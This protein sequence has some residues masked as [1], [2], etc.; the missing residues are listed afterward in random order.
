[1]NGKSDSVKSQALPP[2]GDLEGVP[3]RTEGVEHFRKTSCQ[4]EG[5]LEE[6]KGL[7]F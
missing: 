6:L 7:D 2:G 1:M 4:G 3:G 5:E